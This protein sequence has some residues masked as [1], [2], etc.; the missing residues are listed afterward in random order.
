MGITRIVVLFSAAMILAVEAFAATDG[1]RFDVDGRDQPELTFTELGKTVF[2]LGCGRAVVFHV[3]YPGRSRPGGAVTFVVSNT[4]KSLKY[5]GEMEDGLGE[6]NNTPFVVSWNLGLNQGQDGLDKKLNE[7]FSLIT[8][9]EPFSIT[10]ETG[11]YRIPPVD[12][13]N[14]RKLFMDKC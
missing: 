11:Q 13:R 7:L 2:Y 12:V 14:A 1:W 3:M 6:D 4:K 5:N 9:P 10:A 8:T